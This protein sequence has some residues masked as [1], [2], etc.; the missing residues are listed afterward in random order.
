MWVTEWTVDMLEL[1]S[2]D[3]KTRDA[4]G[5]QPKVFTESLSTTVVFVH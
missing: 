4:A 2:R 1:I 5:N 3:V